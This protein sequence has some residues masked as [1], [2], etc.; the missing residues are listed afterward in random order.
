MLRKKVGLHGSG[1]DIKKITPKN[2][3]KPWLFNQ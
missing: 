1:K 2:S 3:K